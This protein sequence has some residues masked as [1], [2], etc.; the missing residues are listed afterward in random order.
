MVQQY[1]TAVCKSH[2][3]GFL[4][5]WLL[6]SGGDT[7]QLVEDVNTELD[8]EHSVSAPFNGFN[9][10]DG[11][12]TSTKK[13]AH[14]EMRNLKRRVKTVKKKKGITEATFAESPPPPRSGIKQKDWAH[15]FNVAPSV[16]CPIPTWLGHIS[17]RE[18][19]VR[20]WCCKHIPH[21]PSPPQCSCWAYCEGFN[22]ASGAGLIEGATA[23]NDSCSSWSRDARRFRLDW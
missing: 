10:G 5:G 18:R 20:L 15:R 8:N 16:Y 17:P 3:S 6:P 11:T 13:N 2:E 12:K 19:G 7:N 21:I 1:I 22:T 14:R 23:K 4:C 9:S